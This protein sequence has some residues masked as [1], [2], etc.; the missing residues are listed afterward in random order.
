MQG[1]TNK[2][3]LEIFSKKQASMISFWYLQNVVLSVFALV[4][5]VAN[6]QPQF[7]VPI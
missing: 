3:V 7:S 1:K 4:S 5:Q 6:H 2:Q